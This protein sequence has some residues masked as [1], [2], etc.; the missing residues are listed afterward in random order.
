MSVN[1]GPDGLRIGAV[2]AQTGVT[3]D[4]VRYYEREGLL[5]AAVRTPRGARVFPVQTVARIR[6]LK[7]AQAAGL[8][9]R[10]LKQLVGLDGGRSRTACRR[11]RHVLAER[12]HDVDA[13]LRE[14]LTFRS[15]LEAHLEACDKALETRK[16]PACPSLNALASGDE[17]NGELSR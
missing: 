12:L 2:A 7:Q 10:D 16:E 17:L 9:L 6:F 5:P 14:V 1:G 8:T 13:R 4:A 3:A 11:M 15:A